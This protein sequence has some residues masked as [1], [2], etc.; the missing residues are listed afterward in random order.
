MDP[1]APTTD[2]NNPPPVDPNAPVPT[3]PVTPDPMASAPA[4]EPAPAAPVASG[5]DLST[6]PTPAPMATPAPAPA[7]SWNPAPVA[8]TPAVMPDPVLAPTPAPMA[9]PEPAPA[10]SAAP[11]WMAPLDPQPAGMTTPTTPEPMA[12][13]PAPD[14]MM[15]P[16]FSAPQP[17]TLAPQAP[18]PSMD[19]VPTDLS[20]LVD[21]PMSMPN[22]G[23]TPAVDPGLS[24]PSAA[25]T[26]VTSVINT[27]EHKSMPIWI[28]IAGG[29]VLLAVIG[30]S[31]YFILG[32]GQT[33]STDTTS[34]P[35]E[36]NT[37]QQ[38]PL[39]NPPAPIIQ[40]QVAPAA[41]T[42][43]TFGNLQATP[44]S[45]T[46]TSSSAIDLLRE[47]QATAQ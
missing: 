17:E 25:P 30:A 37:A 18:A 11:S 13:T 5:W 9:T 24:I 20:Q 15:Q 47:R 19:S 31:A 44:S 46:A 41:G 21:Q 22:V 28:W 42:G 10:P 29:L 6:A 34:V 35:A 12:P 36:T 8:P 3:P 45:S 39:T 2:P 14:P 4:P 16:T 7:P 40:P 23:S 43:S 33:A 38:P 26:D 1:T 32:I 27:G